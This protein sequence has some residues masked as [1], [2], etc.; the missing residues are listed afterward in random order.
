MKVLLCILLM[1]SFLPS[2]GAV[3]KMGLMDCYRQ[4]LSY[5]EAVA[6]SNEEINIAKAQFIQ[7]LGEVLPKVTFEA[8]VFLQD[9]AAGPDAGG[10]EVSQTF[11]RLSRPELRLGVEQAL[12][13][14]L[15]EFQAMKISKLDR[16]RRELQK[17]DVERLLFQ[18]VAVAFLS[19]ALIEA[20]IATT[21]KIIGI[22]KAQIGELRKRIDLGK[23]RESEGTQQQADLALLEAELEKLRGDRAVAYEMLSFLTGLHPQPQILLTKE[24]AVDP[25][26][27]DFYVATAQV[28]YDV[29]ASEKEMEIA[30]RNIKVQQGD[31]LPQADLNAGFYPYRAGFQSEI[32]WDVD[33]RMTA[34]LFNG[35]TIGRIKEA[36]SQ[37]KQ[38][39]FRAEERRRIATHETRQNYEA[40]SSS[41]RQ[42]QKFQSASDISERSYRQQ[43]GDFRL[44]LL[45][46]FD[47]LQSQRSWFT[48]LRQRNVSL[49]QVWVDWFRLQVAS[50]VMP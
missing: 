21:S 29:R 7:A 19:I 47:L 28:R 3:E 18:D 33:I 14:G 20:D 42:Y 5:S 32:D 40:L 34:P 38:A 48:A 39:E 27:V 25:K 46:N 44:G 22:S 36:K 17:A 8:S 23:S 45:D 43:A 35:V 16:K 30:R 12:F 49:A 24:T 6:I 26:P 37:A 4:A 50:G 11:T 1:F 31:L 15:K 9:P 41:R 2:A 10:N 13:R